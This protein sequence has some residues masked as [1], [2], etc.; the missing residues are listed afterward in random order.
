MFLCA[1]KIDPN[2]SEKSLDQKKS[3]SKRT[4][5]TDWLD[6]IDDDDNDYRSLFIKLPEEQNCFFL[7]HLFNGLFSSVF[8]CCCIWPFEN[9]ARRAR[10]KK[11]FFVL[12]IYY[13]LT[14]WYTIH[15]Q[16]KKIILFTI[17]NFNDSPKDDKYK[18]KIP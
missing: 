4:T 11:L 5:Y 15:T 9:V 8:F 12:C 17:I 16:T 2:F 10:M 1:W 6:V 13:H 14:W 7:L 18:N 3:L